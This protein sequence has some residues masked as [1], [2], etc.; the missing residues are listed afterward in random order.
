MLRF[1]LCPAVYS[2]TIHVTLTHG[3]CA[4]VPLSL[5]FLPTHNG[6]SYRVVSHRRAKKAGVRKCVRK[7][8]PSGSGRTGRSGHQCDRQQPPHWPSVVSCPRWGGGSMARQQ[9][10]SALIL[11][12]YFQWCSIHADFVCRRRH[13]GTGTGRESLAPSPIPTSAE[14]YLR[15][16]RIQQHTT[17]MASGWRK[18]ASSD[19][20]YT[21]LY[22]TTLQLSC[23]R[24]GAP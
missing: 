6:H 10:S 13:T 15:H 3:P 21:L 23:S 11:L 18:S 4:P 24:L 17:T 7:C 19:E 9:D 8:L 2:A 12:Y 14:L 5:S 16:G 22:F 1:H 20:L